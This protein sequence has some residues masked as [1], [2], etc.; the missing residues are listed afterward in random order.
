MQRELWLCLGVALLT[1]V[2]VIAYG[3]VAVGMQLV[4][5][6]YMR[7]SAVTTT[8]NCPCPARAYNQFGG[9][10]SAGAP[11]LIKR[12]LP[13][14]LLCLPVFITMLALALPCIYARCGFV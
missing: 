9:Y 1:V 6:R 5:N 4:D 14:V 8:H 3:V 10:S 11:H 2:G 7:T 12:A 13:S